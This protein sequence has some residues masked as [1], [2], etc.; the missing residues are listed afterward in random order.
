MQRTKILPSC[1][2]CEHYSAHKE[3]ESW[4][5]SHIAWWVHI[6]DAKP[7][8]SNLKQF[9]FQNTKC[10]K[11]SNKNKSVPHGY[12]EEELERDNPYNGWLRD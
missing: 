3:T 2:S 11:H 5:M 4:E 9:P 8:V 10:I 7:N 6:C 12:T 1:R